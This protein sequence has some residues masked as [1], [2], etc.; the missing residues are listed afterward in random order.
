MI[1]VDQPNCFSPELKVA[2]SS[3]ND[4]T[5]LNR[6]INNIHQASVV[7]SRRDFCNLAGVGY[8]GCVYQIVSYEPGNTYDKIVEV[9]GAQPKAQQ[10]DALY[11]ETAGVGLFLP[12]ADCVATVVYDPS[13]RAV[14]LA[15]LGRHSSVA[16]LLPKLINYMSQ[17]GTNPADIVIWMAPSVQ[18][19]SYI[20]EYFDHTEDPG[21]QDY[22]IQTSG[23]I[24]LDLPGYNASLAQQAGVL[25]QNIHRSDVDTATNPN[26]FS[27]SQGDTSGRFA[28]VAQM[29]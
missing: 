18:R 1:A 2:V 27:H 28:I 19:D 29:Y 4:G 13:R 11:T 17:K 9:T 23:G 21:W 25:P 12:V 7:R 8:D 24:Q 14:A 26:Y 10:A 5:M 16:K 6:D 20:M 3:R 15:H 22:V